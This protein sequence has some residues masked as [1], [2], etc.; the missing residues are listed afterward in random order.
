MPGPVDFTTACSC[1]ATLT[2]T[3][4]TL[5]NAETAPHLVT[6]M[7]TGVFH[8]GVCARCGKHV[9]VD[10]WFLYQDPP[11]DVLVHVFP[12]AYRH[13]YLNLQQQLVPLHRLCGIEEEGPVQIVFGID[14]LL[15]FLRGE[16]TAPPPVLFPDATP[17]FDTR[18]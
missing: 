12:R 7:E 10:K 6:Q 2:I 4:Y 9:Q 14:G 17:R 11:L 3:T 16:H 13:A 5:V 15:S 18:H 8:H 1:G